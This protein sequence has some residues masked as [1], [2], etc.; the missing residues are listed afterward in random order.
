MSA[1]SAQNRF[2]NAMIYYC[3]YMWVIIYQNTHT[4][5]QVNLSAVQSCLVLFIFACTYIY[6]FDKL[7]EDEESV[8]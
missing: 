2:S 5:L 6:G 7:L 1:G 8:S 3:F 4:L